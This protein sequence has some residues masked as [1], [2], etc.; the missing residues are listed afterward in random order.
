MGGILAAEVRTY[1]VVG[2]YGGE[3]FLIV[4]TETPLASLLDLAERIRAAIGKGI[5][6]PGTP[7]G[8]PLTA[9]IGV[10]AMSASDPNIDAI[11]KRADDALYQ[12]KK[13]GRN[14]VMGSWTP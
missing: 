14:R 2:R 13:E 4:V 9:S 3:E 11:I 12:A 6:L 7:D 8:V 1:D 10:A 5:R